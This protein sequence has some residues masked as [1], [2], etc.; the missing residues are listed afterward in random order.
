[1]QITK[2]VH[3]CLLVQTEDR[4]GL[5]DPGVFSQDV[6]PIDQI[7]RLDDLIIS[8]IHPDHFSAEI[9]K[10]LV[11]KFPGL[12]I[13]APTE[14]VT[15]L[16]R[17]GVNATDQASP[18]IEFFDSPHET[19]APLF[20]QPQQVGVHYLDQLTNPGDSHH[21]SV[22]KNILALPIT[23]PWGSTIKALNLVLEL[24][25]KYVIPIHDWHWRDEARTQ[26]YENFE[27]KL[28]EQGIHFF[29]AETGMPMLIDD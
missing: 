26:T 28:A 1:M 5:F 13:T 25:P 19:V 12:V 23:G 20:P 4:V 6:L 2:Y 11:K 16:A 27:K 29:K 9:I 14:V 17:E 15:E 8:H 22:S 7:D 3:A 10:E 21:F 24:R 18:G